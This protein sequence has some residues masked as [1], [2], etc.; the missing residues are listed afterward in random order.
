MRIGEVASRTGVSVPTIRFY[1]ERGI[2]PP[3][4]RADNGYRIYT[5][6]DLDRLGFITRARTLD[7][8]LEEIGE[9]LGLREQKK[10]PCA[11]VITQIDAKL[12]EVE[13][14]IE[15]LI[16]LRAELQQLKERA[17]ELPTAEIQAQSCVCHIIENQQLQG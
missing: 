9:I 7:F 3:P 13:R 10:T 8:G 1:E 12:E 14:K 5:E 15:S 2:L 17:T 4:T 11:Y 16:R 6:T